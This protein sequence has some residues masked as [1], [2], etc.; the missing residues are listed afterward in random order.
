MVKTL[1]Y[2]CE[3]YKLL[4]DKVLCVDIEMTHFNGNIAMLGLYKPQDGPVEVDT[5]IKG[6]NLNHEELKEAFRDCKLLITYNGLHH[7]VPKIRAE[8][9]DVL[10]EKTPVID[11]FLFARRLNL[12]TSLKTLGKLGHID[13]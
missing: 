12:K 5:F 2:W 10:P 13:L 1:L 7:D 3:R 8:F 4:K 9:P 11:L 6:K